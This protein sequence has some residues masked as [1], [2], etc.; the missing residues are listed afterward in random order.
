MSIKSESTIERKGGIHVKSIIER[1]PPKLKDFLG[2]E[3]SYLGVKGAT[4]ITYMMLKACQA[5]P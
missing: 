3:D 5:I 1:T 4:G 2:K